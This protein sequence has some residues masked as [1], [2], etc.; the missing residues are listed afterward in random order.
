MSLI[1]TALLAASTN[2]WLR[3]RA[4]KTAFVRRSVRRFMPGEHVEDAL[5]AARTL[6]H[7]GIATILTALGENLEGAAEAELVTAH[8][9]RVFE[10]VHEMGLDAQVSVKPTQLGLDLDPALCERNV[11]RLVQCAEQ[12]GN[13]LWIDMESSPYVDRTLALYRRMRAI[14]PRVGLALQAYLHRTAQDLEDL[15][16]LGPAV[17]IVKGAYLEPPAIAWP[18]KADVDESYYRLCVRLLSPDA[19]AAGARLHIATHDPTLIA[20][21]R[22]HAGQQAETS[23]HEFAMLYGIAVRQQQALVAAGEKMRVLI[24]YGESWFPWYMRRLAERPANIWFVLK[25]ALRR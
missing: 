21:L 17:R 10:Q 20:R 19:G 18:R 8:Y 22:Q 7:Q 11:Q 15:I 12:H 2:R 14:S 16:P 9:V 13:L 1:R 5:A 25:S 23:P 3:E 24:S 4:T 6:Q